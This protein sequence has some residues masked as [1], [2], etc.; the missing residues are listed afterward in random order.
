[1]VFGKKLELHQIAESQ[2]GFFTAKQAEK[3]GFKKNHFSHYVQSGEWIREDRGLYRLSAY[4]W[5][6]RQELWKW[7]LWSRNRNEEPQA[8]FAHETALELYNLSD[9]LPS[10]IRLTVPRDFRRS[11]PLPSVL[12]VHLENLR[13]SEVRLVEGLPATTVAKTLAN[14]VEAGFSDRLLKQAAR[15][16]LE[17][18]ILATS[19]FQKI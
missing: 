4:P 3:A 8:V 16:A 6:P 17:K 7:Y 2:D 10:K 12:K 9:V 15:E 5:S 11:G 1:L 19:D 13:K 18:G 14:L